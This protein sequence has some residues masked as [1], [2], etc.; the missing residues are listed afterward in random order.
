MTNLRDTSPEELA[1][2]MVSPPS[3][4]ATAPSPEQILFGVKEP[5][6]FPDNNIF[7]IEWPVHTP[8]L[9]E[10]Y[11]G[12]RDPGWAPNRLP[13][14]SLDPESFSADQRAAIAYW[15]ALL[16]VFDSSGPA[17]FAR[18]M[19]HTYE[20]HQEDP[21]RKCFF[22]ITRD[23]VNHEEIC[24]RAIQILTPGGPVGHTPTTA[25]GRLAQNN[26]KWYYH[27][28]ARYW[29][30]FKGSVHKYPLAILFTSFL[31]GEIAAANLF[32]TMNERTTIPVLKE[33][34]RCVGK[35]EARHLAIC[36]TVLRNILPDLD[37]DNKAIIT[38]QIRAGYVF[39]SG[40]LYEPPDEFWDLPETFLPAHRLLEACARDAGLGLLTLEERAENWRQAVLR[41]KG[42]VEK[43]GIVFPAIPEIGIDGETVAFDPADIIPVF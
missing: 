22:S 6:P 25:L 38:K 20:S 7:P 13:W 27:N 10:I 4:A 35:D 28:G 9:A 14:D 12:A 29:N 24:Q 33:A 37:I 42:E 34:F 36:L 23:E 32:H 16:S 26:A 40:I 43:Y 21:I 3:G 5:P 15:F 2:A 11:D 31:M 17:V 19:I 41:L 39:L 30:G 18:A 8:K 1:D